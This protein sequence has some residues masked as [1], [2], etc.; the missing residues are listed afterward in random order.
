M[1]SA[2]RGKFARRNQRNRS[3]LKPRQVS[4]DKNSRISKGGA[5]QFVILEVL[6]YRHA[7][8]GLQ[9]HYLS[10]ETVLAFGD[11]GPPPRPPKTGTAH[12][13][14]SRAISRDLVKNKDLKFYASRRFI[15]GSY[16]PKAKKGGPTYRLIQDYYAGEQQYLRLIPMQPTSGS[17]EAFEK[18]EGEFKRLSKED[19]TG[20]QKHDIHSGEYCANR[21]RIL[22]DADD[23]VHRVAID[24]VEYDW[25]NC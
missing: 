25:K 16:D 14:R 1:T 23:N 4:C 19:I 20:R 22:L 10:N 7:L 21:I 12:E 15:F 11:P 17:D 6:G 18:L 2:R 8:S 5:A 13:L 24:G 9:A 3:S